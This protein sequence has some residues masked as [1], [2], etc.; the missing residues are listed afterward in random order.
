MRS[1]G[2]NMQR[3]TNLKKGDMFR[4]IEKD[5]IF[6]VGEIVTLKDDDGTDCPYFWNEDKSDWHCAYFSD[7][8]P[9]AK[10]VR[11]KLG[12][13]VSKLKIKKE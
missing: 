5:S 9:Y 10:T 1:K 12:I 8:E 4:V 3:P 11:E 2:I 7:L 13:D 6:K